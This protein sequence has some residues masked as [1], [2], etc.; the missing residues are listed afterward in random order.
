[1]RTIEVEVYE[2]DELSEEVQKRVADKW[3]EDT[4]LSFM[5]EAFEERLETLG[6][7]DVKVFWSGF[8][9]QG[10]GASFSGFYRGVEIC[11]S[12]RYC[13]EMTMS[14]DSARILAKARKLAK[15]FYVELESAYE[16]DTAFE[17][18]RENIVLNECEFFADGRIV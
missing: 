16:Y 17:N 11:Q 13:H 8:Y 12:G 9:S 1:M 6:F 5:V 7:S 3:A 14:C 4:D 18:V 10:D 15:E 2:F